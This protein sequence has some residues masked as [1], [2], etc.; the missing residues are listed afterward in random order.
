MK[1]WAL[2]LAA[3]LAVTACGHPL[4]PASAL[5]PTA[6]GQKTGATPAAGPGDGLP[7]LGVRPNTPVLGVQP[8]TPVLGVD[9]YAVSNYP[10]A[11]VRADGQR[12]LFYIKYVLR[13]DAV[14]IVWG[15][16]AA[17]Y[18]A[19]DVA[20][21]NNSLSAR[22]VAILTRIAKS[23]QLQV[24][25]R[26]IIFVTNGQD[27]WEGNIK[28]ANPAQWFNSYYRTELPYL[29]LAQ[30]LNVS[31]FVTATEMHGMNDSTLWPFFLRRV[32]NVYHGVVSYSAWDLDYL[33]QL[34]P[35]EY[36]GMDMYQQFRLGPSATSGQVTT[37]WQN[38][39]RQ[40]PVSV[41]QRTAID[42]TGIEARAGAYHHPDALG[43][44]GRPNERVQVN[45]FTAACRT[46]HRYHMRGVF[47][48]KVDLTDNPASPATSLSTFEGRQG[49]MAISNCAHI[50]RSR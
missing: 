27:P 26:P 21:T 10:P 13:A 24:E 43:F 50:L 2:W 40:V 15:L 11:V 33:K 19:D 35:V 4:I 17:N 46:V 23:Y 8:D 18:T 38:W 39:F 41:L 32:A 20:V 7:V 28:A 6:T 34:L 25:Y 36:V 3:V 45:W 16:Y 47:F 1:R 49:A 22:N 9:L 14:G 29:R 37:A 31:E 30:K 12:A 48:W 5:R 44:P 42:E